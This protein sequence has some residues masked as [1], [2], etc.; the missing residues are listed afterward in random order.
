MH[1]DSGFGEKIKILSFPYRH[2]NYLWTSIFDEIEKQSPCTYPTSQSTCDSGRHRPQRCQPKVSGKRAQRERNDSP[3]VHC[4]RCAF[5]SASYIYHIHTILYLTE[6]TKEE[7]EMDQFDMDIWK[8]I[9]NQS[10]A[11]P[12]TTL[13]KNLRKKN[14]KKI[15]PLFLSHVLLLFILLQRTYCLF[16]TQKYYKSERVIFDSKYTINADKLYHKALKDLEEKHLCTHVSSYR[17]KNESWIFHE[18]L[19]FCLLANI[20]INVYS[21]LYFAYKTAL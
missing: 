16:C 6:S 21:L 13:Q 17:V 18:A 12:H 15:L 4:Y 20:F 9:Q 7:E 2:Q 10:N 14:H 19:Y 8:E 5:L 11:K 1:P 3:S